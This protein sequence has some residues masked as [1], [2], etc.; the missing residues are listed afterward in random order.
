MSTTEGYADTL[1]FAAINY[2]IY[3]F[4]IALFDHEMLEGIGNTVEF[5]LYIILFTAIMLIVG[6]MSTSIGA[7]IYDA[8]YKLLGETRNYRGTVR[9]ISYTTA[10]LVLSG[11]PLVGS[12]FWV[13]ELYL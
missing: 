1:T 13:Y 4:L 9:F 3:G 6:I 2:L 10:V 7:A 12:I 11:I 5:S 8:V